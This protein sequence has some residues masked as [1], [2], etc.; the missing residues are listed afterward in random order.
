MGENSGCSR[1]LNSPIQ[2]KDEK[3]IERYI[4]NDR[5]RQKPKR[6]DG[7]PHRTQQGCIEVIDEGKDDTAEDYPQV[8]AHHA[9]YVL[10]NLQ[11]PENRVEPDENSHVQYQGHD[12]YQHKRTEYATAQ[13]HRIS[14]AIMQREYGAAAHRQ[15]Q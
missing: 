12:T 7:I 13:D 5:N 4:Q 9:I 2:L 6:S 3:Q 15:S 10:R 1:T 8:A 11:Q 14:G